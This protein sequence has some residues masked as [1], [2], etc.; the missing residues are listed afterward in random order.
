MNDLILVVKTEEIIASV[1]QATGG[2]DFAE[3]AGVRV[4]FNP[5][6]TLVEAKIMLLNDDV[7][8]PEEQ[9]KAIIFNPDEHIDESRDEVIITITD[10]DGKDVFV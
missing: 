10:D 6:Q 4:T 5:T 1:G 9:F 7:V 2:Q 8:E 3:T